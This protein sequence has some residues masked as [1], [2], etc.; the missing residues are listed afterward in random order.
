MPSDSFC[1]LHESLKKELT[2]VLATLANDQ[3][4]F[5][6]SLSVPSD[7]GSAFLAYSIGKESNLTID[8]LDFRYSPVEWMD[9]WLPLGDANNSLNA[10]VQ[11]FSIGCAMVVDY[12]ERDRLHD[13]FISDCAN[14]CL[15]V[16]H[17][18]N[19]QGLFGC[20]WYKVLHMSDE[21]H[22]V[23]AES[24]HRL[25]SGRALKEAGSLFMS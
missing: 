9:T 5:G 21:D 14:V 7:Y 23:V 3:D 2:Q 17:E 24:F 16:L 4:N 15:E 6:F 19:E 20:I 18:C 11:E 12:G 25:N 10:V 22:P 8:Y 1:K 13:Q